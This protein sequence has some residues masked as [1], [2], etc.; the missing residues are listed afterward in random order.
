MA[1]SQ[2]HL[3]ALLLPTQP[4]SP[5]TSAIA[6][7]A[8]SLSLP[9]KLP[10]TLKDPAYPFLPYRAPEHLGHTPIIQDSA[11]SLRGLLTSETGG[12]TGRK[13]VLAW[14]RAG[15]TDAV[16]SQWMNEQMK[17]WRSRWGELTL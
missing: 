9:N 2:L 10:P 5:Y 15:R 8:I 7:V 12:L 1:P 3:R 14:V 4:L 16:S 6:L 13:L 17:E 11:A